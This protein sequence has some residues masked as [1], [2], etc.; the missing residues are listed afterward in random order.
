MAL[1][2]RARLRPPV[3]RFAAEYT[4][5]LGHAPPPLRGE[6]LNDAVAL[7]AYTLTRTDDAKGDALA[8]AFDD[9]V[10]AKGEVTDWNADGMARGPSLIDVTGGLTFADRFPLELTSATFAL[11]RVRTG[12]QQ[13]NEI[14]VGT[15]TLISPDK[16]LSLDG[17]KT[18]GEASEGQFITPSALAEAVRERFEAHG[19]RRMALALDSCH[20]GVMG[21][22]LETP[23]VA[24]LTGAASSED[25]YATN[26]GPSTEMWYADA[27]SSAFANQLA[28]AP[29]SSIVKR[30]Q[31][32][33]A[34][35]RGSHPHLYNGG[36]FGQASTISIGSIVTP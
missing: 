6:P 4:S 16:Y 14:D 24:L 23:G 30:Y 29:D 33:Y 36:R 26:Y 9:V 12:V 17:E 10:Q 15:Q 19:F 32:T 1:E 22:A 3:P 13:C 28:T 7:A 31:D 25:S 35:V 34:S 8:T 21:D 5:A 27:L 18:P 20:A 2:V 11:W